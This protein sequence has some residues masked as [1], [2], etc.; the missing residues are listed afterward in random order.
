VLTILEN[1]RVIELARPVVVISEGA[2]QVVLTVR[3]SA[4]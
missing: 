1:E 2:Q 4:R 3:R